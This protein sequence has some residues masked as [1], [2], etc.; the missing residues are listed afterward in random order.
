MDKCFLF[1]KETSLYIAT[2]PSPVQSVVHGA[3]VEWLAR[4]KLLEKLYQW[5]S[6]SLSN[7]SSPSY[8]IL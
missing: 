2:D 8:S 5:V 6:L 1:D 7:L 3:C 4:I